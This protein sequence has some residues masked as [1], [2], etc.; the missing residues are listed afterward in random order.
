MIPAEEVVISDFLFAVL[1]VTGVGR[2]LFNLY[3]GVAA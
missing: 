1:L 3:D 2:Q